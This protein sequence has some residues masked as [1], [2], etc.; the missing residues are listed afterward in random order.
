MSAYKQYL[1]NKIQA[2]AEQANDSIKNIPAP[3]SISR[4]TRQFC[5]SCIHLIRSG[6]T[7]H[8]EKRMFGTKLERAYCLAFKDKDL[9]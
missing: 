9:V 1:E 5:T 6:V 2:K 7:Y 8:C 4:D 3:P